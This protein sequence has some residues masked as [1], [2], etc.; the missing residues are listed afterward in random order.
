M[1]KTK[2]TGIDADAVGYLQAVLDQAPETAVHLV[3]HAIRC[4]RIQA[5]LND[6]VLSLLHLRREVEREG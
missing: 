1:K 2:L 6:Y 5:C 3:E 4:V